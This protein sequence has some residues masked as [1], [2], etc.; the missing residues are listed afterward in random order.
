M[1]ER[2]H[3]QHAAQPK[4]LPTQPYLH[5]LVHSA[6]AAGILHAAQETC[7]KEG[8]HTLLAVPHHGQVQCLQAY[9]RDS[10]IES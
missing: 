6:P 7:V 10:R 1:G 8:H 2:H 9:I 4:Q 3:E 5:C